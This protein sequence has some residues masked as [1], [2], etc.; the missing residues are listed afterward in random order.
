M[1]IEIDHIEKRFGAAAPVLRDVS[2]TIADGEMAALLGPSGSGKTTLLRIIAGLEE[3]TS[4]RIVLMGRDVSG[5]SAR[6]RKVGFVFQN[7]ALFRH[8]TVAENVAF[9]LTV[10]KGA[11]RPSKDAVRRKVEELLAMVQLSAFATRYP[12]QLSG[13]QQQRVALARA[14]AVE[15][16]VLLL[17]E[18]FGALDAQVREEL[19]QW[20]RRLH[21]E[22]KFTA[23]FVT[24]DQEEALQ[25]A[26][27][28][29]VMKD[30]R[31]E[32]ADPPEEIWTHPK[33]RFVLEFLCDV[34]RLAGVIENGRLTLGT[35]TLDLEGDEAALTDGPVDVLLR[36]IDAQLKRTYGL[37]QL[38]VNI[39]DARP[40]GGAVQVRVDP[41]DWYPEPF[42]AILLEDALPTRGNTY[43]MSL[44][45]A[46]LYRGAERLSVRIHPRQRV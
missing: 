10:R 34:N 33:T 43:F 7:Y 22:L 12:A 39:L 25:I 31:I 2:L 6:E 37:G 32:Q 42:N 29:V 27:R 4:G 45:R 28:V 5:V 9:G 26:D 38:P 41:L 3:E 19:R 18:P 24:H 44:E 30:G 20:I 35:L 15:P 23:V 16:S 8:M 13:G 36:P 14:L 40:K 17:D 21:Q 1:S 46:Y 11:E